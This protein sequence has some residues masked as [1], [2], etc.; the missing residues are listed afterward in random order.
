MLYKKVEPKVKFEVF[1]ESEWLPYPHPGFATR[2]IHAGQDPE[3]IHGSVNVPIHMSSTFAQRDIA[4]P[5][6][7]FDYTR[8]GNPTREALEKCMA[9]VEYGNYAIAFASGCGATASVLHTLYQGDHILV[10]DDVYGGTQRYIRRFFKEKH[11]YKADF[12]DM[13]KVENV[14]N[15][16]TKETKIVWIESP[17]NPTIK[18]IDIA[19]TIKVVKE[20]NKD[21]IVVSDNTFASPYIQN[22]M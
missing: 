20:Y 13:S 11:G 17:T 6:G 18:L 9:A 21:I 7:K 19:E 12:V 14:K 10:C 3:P 22:P 2:A 1:P 4:E 5:F 15:G 8:G 16:L